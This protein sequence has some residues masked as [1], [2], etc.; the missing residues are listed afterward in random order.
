[1]LG[2]GLK[3]ETH[4]QS[5]RGNSDAKREKDFKNGYAFLCESFDGRTFVGFVR[6]Q[7]KCDKINQNDKWKDT[8]KCA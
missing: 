1:M 2:K 8:C 5:E 3:D 4:S 6:N 7:C